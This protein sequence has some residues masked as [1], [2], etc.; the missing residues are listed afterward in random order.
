MYVSL[1]G[2]AA[3][4]EILRD[5]NEIFRMRHGQKAHRSAVQ[6]GENT[7]I[8]A[9]AKC[10]RQYD[11]RCNARIPAQHAGAEPHVAPELLYHR[12]PSGLM[13]LFLDGGPASH[14]SPGSPEGFSSAHAGPDLLFNRKIQVRLQFFVQLLIQ[15]FL[16]EQPTQPARYVSQ[17]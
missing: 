15:L 14:L 17:P 4:I 1:D 16:S 9:N 8:Q 5:H 12:F 10:K 6:D 3:L 2:T 11:D 7:G 13:H